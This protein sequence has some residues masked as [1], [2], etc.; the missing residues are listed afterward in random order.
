MS[1]NGRTKTDAKDAVLSRKNSIIC[2]DQVNGRIDDLFQGRM[3]ATNQPSR[4]YKPFQPTEYWI[5]K[6]DIYDGHLKPHPDGKGISVYSQ[7]A[8]KYPRLYILRTQWPDLPAGEQQY[9][10]YENGATFGNMLLCFRNQDAAIVACVVANQFNLETIDLSDLIPDW[11]NEEKSYAIEVTQRMA[12]FYGQRSGENMRPLLY[13][14][15]TG[16]NNTPDAGFYENTSKPYYLLVSD[17]PHPPALNTLIENHTS[18]TKI[19]IAPNA[20]RITEGTPYPPR[21]WFFYEGG[22]FETL[23]GNSYDDTITSH[24]I[25]FYGFKNKTIYFHAD[26][27]STT[28]GLKVEVMVETGT[29]RAYDTLTY[30]AGDF[31]KFTPTAELPLARIVYDPAST[32]ATINTAEA[33][34]R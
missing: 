1:V 10:G 18:N 5:Q 29:W 6:A 13:V 7:R 25:P 28:D 24:P 3:K 2:T 33:V 12:V 11:R 31:V 26:T 16:R 27:D 23:M 9:F 20:F 8:F 22:N 4:N 34:L 19:P 17:S 14:L 32:G 15:F 21:K 30:T